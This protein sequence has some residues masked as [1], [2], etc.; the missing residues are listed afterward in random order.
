MA[1]VGRWGL[2]YGIAGN[3]IKVPQLPGFALGNL[4]LSALALFVLSAIKGQQIEPR[5]KRHQRTSI[6]LFSRLAS[7][8][9]PSRIPLATRN[10]KRLVSDSPNSED[11]SRGVTSSFRSWTSWKVPPP[12]L[13]NLLCSCQVPSITI[14]FGPAPPCPGIGTVVDLKV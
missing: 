3:R 1:Q 13:T 5:N 12:P 7:S 9:S 2:T 4:I 14:S 8:K 11:H 10:H 6:L